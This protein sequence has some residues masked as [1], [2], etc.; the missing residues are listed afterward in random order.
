V[1]PVVKVLAVPASLAPMNAIP[2]DASTVA[3]VV[4]PPANSTPTVPVSVSGVP[5]CKV[6]I[7]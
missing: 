6:G 2:D 4:A 7:Y 3:V 1:D 5:T